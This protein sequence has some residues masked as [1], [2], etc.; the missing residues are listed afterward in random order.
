MN[1]KAGDKV[2]CIRD[3]PDPNFINPNGVPPQ[4]P[5]LCVSEVGVNGA[6]FPYVK[7]VGYPTYNWTHK[8]LPPRDVGYV[9]EGFR[10]VIQNPESVTK[11]RSR[12]VTT[13]LLLLLSLFM[14]VSCGRY[15]GPGAMFAFWDDLDEQQFAKADLDGSGYISDEEQRILRGQWAK[16][17]GLV[18]YNLALYRDGKRI[19]PYE[20]AVIAGFVTDPLDVE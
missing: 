11:S 8:H 3:F 13:L 4:G 9:P 5:I 7:I 10:K 17:H 6:K 12:K 14:C 16:E 20:A 2:V 15:E 18:I 19:S 1:F